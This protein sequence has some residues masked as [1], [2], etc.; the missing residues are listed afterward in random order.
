MIRIGNFLFHYRNGLFPLFYILIFL[1]G[2]KAFPDS[3]LALIMGILIAALGQGLRA[4]TVGLDYIVRGGRNRRVYA[5]NLVQG[6]LFAHCRNPLYVGNYLILVGVGVASNS[7]LFLTIALPF[8]LFAYRAIIAAE[9]AFLLGKFGNEFTRYCARVNRVLPNFSGLSKSLEGMRFNW[10]RL[11]SAEYGSAYLWMAA[12]ILVS[13]K[14]LWFAGQYS[15]HTAPA[16]ALW[17]ALATV[18]LAYGLARFL[19]KSGK[20]ETA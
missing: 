5:D 4:W 13:F 11:I 6:G 14:N 1:N 18:T 19:K 17:A 16:Q 7:L 8:F 15:I 20:L 10:R 2:P 3:Q 9:E 12:I